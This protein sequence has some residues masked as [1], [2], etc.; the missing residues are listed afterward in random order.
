MK[1]ISYLFNEY[2]GFLAKIK[3]L[4]N[5]V[6]IKVFIVSIEPSKL[7]VQQNNSI[8]YFSSFAV[9]IKN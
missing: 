7:F 4:I 1:I 9:D 6:F 2:R 8:D 5:C 3:I